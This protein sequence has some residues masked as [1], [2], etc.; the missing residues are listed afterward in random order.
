M[1]KQNITVTR[2]VFLQNNEDGEAF[3]EDFDDLVPKGTCTL[4]DL[5]KK[6]ETAERFLLANFLI[7]WA[8]KNPEPLVLDEYSGGNIYYNGDV[9]IKKGFECAGNIICKKLK[10]DGRLVVGEMCWVRVVSVDAEELE[11]MDMGMLVGDASTYTFNTY[12]AA[13]LHGS[14]YV[15]RK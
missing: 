10:I 5:L 1:K 4:S 13:S 15:K 3:I 8:P 14:L 12:G 2:E 9:H 6:C 11:L 7:N